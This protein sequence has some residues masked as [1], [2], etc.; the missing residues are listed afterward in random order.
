MITLERSERERP[1][2]DNNDNSGRPESRGP[3]RGAAARPPASR[4]VRQPARRRRII[5]GL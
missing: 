4:P 5:P 2:L 3:C 1:L